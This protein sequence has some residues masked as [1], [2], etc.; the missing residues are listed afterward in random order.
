MLIW[1]WQIAFKRTTSHTSLAISSL[2]RLI[3]SQVSE[4]PLFECLQMWL[5]PLALF[6]HWCCWLYILSSV[7]WA[8]DCL[9]PCFSFKFSAIF[10]SELRTK[11]RQALYPWAKPSIPQQFLITFLLLLLNCFSSIKEYLF[12]IFMKLLISRRPTKS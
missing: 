6:A 11:L 4:I 9:H 12:K 2:D 1:P 10:F 5:A 7:S 8:L 3:I